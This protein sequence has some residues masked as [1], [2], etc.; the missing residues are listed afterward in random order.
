MGSLL[1]RDLTLGLY[2]YSVKLLYGVILLQIES[3]Y[4]DFFEINALIFIKTPALLIIVMGLNGNVPTRNHE[5]GAQ[6]LENQL[7]A[8]TRHE[9]TR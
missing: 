6:T 8:R 5:N 3:P 9:P 4:S 1:K 2:I 7:T